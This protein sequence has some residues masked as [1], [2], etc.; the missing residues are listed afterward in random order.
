MLRKIKVFSFISH[1]NIIKG[2]VRH[3]CVDVY[4][5]QH[6]YRDQTKTLWSWFS[7]LY[8]PMASRDQN[9]QVYVASAF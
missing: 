4:V 2:R 9:C 6:A 8:L 1:L 5:P 7:P 3:V